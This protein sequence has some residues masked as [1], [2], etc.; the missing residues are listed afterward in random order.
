MASTGNAKPQRPDRDA[1]NRT[2]AEFETNIEATKKK[3]ESVKERID[4]IMTSKN[5]EN[6]PED[7]RGK[8]RARL[9]EIRQQQAESKTERGKLLDQMKQIQSSIAKKNADIKAIR[10]K[11]PFRNVEDLDKHIQMLSGEVDS[12]QMKLVDEKKMLNEISNLRRSRRTFENV[13]TLQ[14]QVDADRVKL[15]ELK[16]SLDSLPG[17]DISDEYAEIQRKIDELS[18]QRDADYSRRQDLFNER[19]T[20][21]KQLNEQLG[22]RRAAQQEYRSAQDAWHKYQEEQRKKQRERIAKQKEEEQRERLMKRVEQER[23]AAQ[24]DAYVEE[25]GTCD[26]LIAHL[27]QYLPKDEPAKA[28]DDDGIKIDATKAPEGK[29][30]LR[31]KDREEESFFAGKGSKKGKKSPKPA[32]PDSRSSTPSST[33]AFKVSMEFLSQFLEIEVDPPMRITEIP[34]TIEALQ[35]R[36]QWYQDNQERVTKERQ[37]AVE[38]KIVKLM[39]E[40]EKE[41]NGQTATEATEEDV[42]ITE[43]VAVTD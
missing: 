8:L 34:T 31:K 5:K 23:E 7:P 35:K 43:V 22:K 27:S 41:M 19:S 32:T 10:S 20:L 28:K 18:Q 42:K 1:Y 4:A 2:L 12:G 3:L 16:K 37:A 25:I 13:T 11:M 40:A 21:Q 30:L 9:A 26:T 15:E 6:A 33:S 24:Y 38:A 14:A 36:R 39:K 17:K 29:M